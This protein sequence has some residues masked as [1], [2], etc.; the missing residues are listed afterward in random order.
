MSV[1]HNWAVNTFLAVYDLRFV[2]FG[3]PDEDGDGIPDWKNHR[4]DVASALDAPPLESLVSPLCVEG[5]DL[6][7]DVLEIEVATAETNLV[8]S[9][10]K[11]IGDG[12][13]ADI[14]LPTNGAAVVSMRDRSLADSF[15]VEWRALDVFDGEFET[16]ALTL[17]T[18]DAL[19]I[20]PFGNGA[21]SEV[22][23]SR[24][25]A[26]GS[27]A[28]V[29][30]WTESAATPYS[31]DEAGLY[32]VSVTHV[33]FFFDDTAYALVEEDSSTPAQEAELRRLTLALCAP[34]ANPAA[35]IA[36]IQLA[37]ERGY[38]EAL[39]LLRGTLSAPRR[40]AVTDIVC[41][42]SLGLLGDAGDL[43]LLRRYAT[44]EPRYATAAETAI[45]RIEER[46]ADDGER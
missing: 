35:R 31:F 11:T 36:A 43:P 39:P 14:P 10:V 30:N 22:A 44:M 8:Y 20:A 24:A 18:G 15:A 45:H 33:G 34:G 38:A 41:L 12:F 3:G 4:A 1:W 28:P 42:G 26:A 13:Y 23:I 27:W 40:D 19:K 16:N 2:T 6:W 9:T 32:L 17:R 29:T 25:T 21:E 5:R 7:R 46:E 37:G